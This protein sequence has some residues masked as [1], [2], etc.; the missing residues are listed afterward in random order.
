MHHFLLEIHSSPLGVLSLPV[1]SASIFSYGF[2]R[3]MGI[4]DVNNTQQRQ[5]AYKRQIDKNPFDP[6]QSK[7]C[8]FLILE[9]SHTPSEFIFIL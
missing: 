6:F 1:F 9:T 5:V 2:F 4:G 7:K 8:S 3:S